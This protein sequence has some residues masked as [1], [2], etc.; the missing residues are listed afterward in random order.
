MAIEK[1][2]QPQV[3]RIVHG[4]DDEEEEEDDDSSTEYDEGGHKY[5]PISNREE[6]I[7]E[8]REST[9]HRYIDSP[10][11]PFQSPSSGRPFCFFLRI[12]D[13]IYSLKEY[14]S[15]FQCNVCLHL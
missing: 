3:L 15:S 7:K 13:L 1:D 12:T 9:S 8:G 2:R 10:D 6:E 4:D 14:L 5:N 11:S